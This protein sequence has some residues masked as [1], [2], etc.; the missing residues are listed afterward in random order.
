MTDTLRAL[1]EGVRGD[2]PHFVFTWLCRKSDTKTVKGERV[3]RRAGE[4]YP[5]CTKR[6]QERWDE[7]RDAVGVTV[8][9]HAGTRAFG[10]TQTIAT[11]GE[12]VAQKLADHTKREMTHHYNRSG[13]EVLRK[14]MQSLETPFEPPPDPPKKRA[15]LRLVG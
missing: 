11:H 12:H 3:V 2:H 15:K 1:L 13:D 7:V 9:W 14:A 5:W 6:L 8:T 10:I 4:R